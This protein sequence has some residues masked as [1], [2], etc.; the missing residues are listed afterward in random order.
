M[1]IATPIAWY[2]MDYWLQSYAYKTDTAWWERF[3]LL[4]HTLQCGPV[5]RI[6]G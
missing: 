4:L 3:D 1:L 2:A 6:V 5:L